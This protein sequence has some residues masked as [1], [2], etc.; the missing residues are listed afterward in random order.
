MSD[1]T[2]YTT[3]LDGREFDN[4]EDGKRLLAEAEIKFKELTEGQGDNVTVT[5]FKDA[6]LIAWHT[7]R[8]I[9][10]TFHKQT[11]GGRGGN[12]ALDCGQEE[13]DATHAVLLLPLSAIHELEDS[14]DSSDAIGTTLVD[15]HGPCFVTGLEDSLLS[16]FGVLD[17]CDIT[18]EHLRR[19]MAKEMPLPRETRVVELSFRV[20]VSAGKGSLQDFFDGLDYSVRSNTPGVVVTNT[21]LTNAEEP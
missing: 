7:N 17:A 8:R 1:T 20:T 14:S 12:D 15:W 10:A 9:E 4:G 6:D 18:E 11:W 19:A 16:Y 21:E 2:I 3:Y 13:F 5:V